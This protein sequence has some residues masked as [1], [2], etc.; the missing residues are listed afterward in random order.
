MYVCILLYDSYSL[1]WSPGLILH[2]QYSL[3]NHLEETGPALL[4]EV[5]AL[6]YSKATH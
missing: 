1:K 6:E 2:D 4:A 3:G 5:G